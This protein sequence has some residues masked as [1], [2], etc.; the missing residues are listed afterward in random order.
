MQFNLAICTQTDG[1]TYSLPLSPSHTHIHTHSLTHTQTHT[2]R[3]SAPKSHTEPA[4]MK[5]RTGT[6]TWNIRQIITGTSTRNI[7][8]IKTGTST[9]NIG[10]IIPLPKLS[11][12]IIQ[13]GLTWN[14]DNQHHYISIRFMCYKSMYIIAVRQCINLDCHTELEYSLC[15]DFC[16]IWL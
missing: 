16:L 6:S 11:M 14:R 1:Y 5:H 4:L 13:C 2:S 15:F 7:G 9:R 3:L 12:R 10:Q 8:Q